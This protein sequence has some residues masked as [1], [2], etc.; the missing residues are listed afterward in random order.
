[1]SNIP[2][3]SNYKPTQ[4]QLE[5]AALFVGPARN[6][7]LY[8]GTRSGKTFKVLDYFCTVA[9]IFPGSRQLVVR[10]TLTSVRQAV[11]LDT[12]KIVLAQCHSNERV[13]FHQS[14]FVFHFENGSEIWLGGLDDSGS[15]NRQQFDKIFGREYCN[16]FFNE[17][18]ELNWAAVVAAHSRLAQ[19]VRGLRNKLIYDCN[20]PSRRHWLHKLFIEKIH[21]ESRVALKKPGDYVSLRMN[22]DSN[23]E[24]LQQEY[25]DILDGFSGKARQRF[26]TGEF[27]DDTENALWKRAWIDSYRVQNVPENLERIVIAVDPAV[28]S[29]ENSDDTGIVAIGKK[30]DHFYVLRDESMK[31]TPNEWAARVATVFND[32]QADRVVAE[33]NNGGDLVVQVLHNT[34]RNLPVTKIHA[35]RGKILRAEPIAGIYEQGRVHHVGE[36]VELEDQMCSFTDSD[37]EDSPDNL[38]ALVYGITELSGVGQGKLVQLSHYIPGMI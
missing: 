37:N 18:S 2:N 17:A 35:R 3:P 1:M 21:P 31:G 10:R 12:M 8:G 7:L 15:E 32:L 19:N 25:F 16:I 24:N 38:D 22:P 29:R 27:T 20:P 9:K 13:R 28:T 5:A 36:F 30:D 6:I 26:V 14:D 4:K 33:T 34:Q 23:R 11:G